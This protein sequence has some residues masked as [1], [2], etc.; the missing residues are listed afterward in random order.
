[1]LFVL[2]RLHFCSQYYNSLALLLCWCLVVFRC[3]SPS[4]SW[5]RA[6]FALRSFCWPGGG[7]CMSVKFWWSLL[8]WWC[9]FLRVATVFRLWN[10]LLPTLLAL[11]FLRFHSDVIDLQSLGHVG[12]GG[13]DL[14]SFGLLP[15]LF[16][17]TRCCVLIGR[18]VNCTTSFGR[19]RLVWYSQLCSVPLPDLCPT[20][21]LT[22]FCVRYLL[23]WVVR[24]LKIVRISVRLLLF[25]LLYIFCCSGFVVVF[26]SALGSHSFVIKFRRGSFRLM[27]C[28]F[29]IRLAD[30]CGARCAF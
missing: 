21:F 13:F 23:W 24:L 15:L 19:L 9:C 30:P 2:G 12:L 5:C 20:C 18:I 16:V 7:D 3:L 10:C 17:G 25:S 8:S 22:L 28:L 14:P 27:V 6:V 26:P 29:V 4:G 11:L 1:M